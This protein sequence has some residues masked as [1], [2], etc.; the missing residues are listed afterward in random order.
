MKKEEKFYSL[1]F[2]EPLLKLAKQINELEQ[3]AVNEEC[4]NSIANLKQEF[5]KLKEKTYLNLAP[6]Q[7]LQI[8]RHPLRPYTLDY[9][10]YLG[11]NWIEL[12]GDRMGK[13]DS[14]IVGGLL[15]LE[16]NRTVM[17]VGTEKGKNIKEKQ[18]RNFG[19]PQPWGYRKALRLFKHA[20]TFSL[21]IITLVDTPG[22]YPG[23]E[24]EAQAQSIA[25]AENLQAM[26]NLTVPIIAII[27]G[28]GG[29]GGALALSVANKVIMLEHAVYS[30]ISPEG[31]A[32][33]LWRTRDKSAEAANNLKITAQELLELG[34]IDEI[35]KEAVGGA[36]KNLE[37][38]SEFLK[39]SI[40]K[41]LNELEALT[42]EDLVKQRQEKFRNYGAFIE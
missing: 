22:A 33:I 10:K 34:L 13:D 17:I 35:I 32:A 11:T 7:K 8:A 40:L 25:I 1:D 19:M 5:R 4:R 15:E 6:H 28:E 42:K 16:E 23:L 26:S 38:T 12:H 36:H 24:A 9:V 2:E 31:C 37:K 20:E 27:T 21:P 14:A 39:Q 29:S 30:V 41:N 3:N 18:K